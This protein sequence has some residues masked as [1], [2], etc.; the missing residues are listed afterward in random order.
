MT[1][2]ACSE[3]CIRCV[4]VLGSVL[5]PTATLAELP[6]FLPWVSWCLSVYSPLVYLALVLAVYT[7]GKAIPL[8]FEL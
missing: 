4:L 3:S 7:V 8:E 5:P 1:L 6:T 2:H